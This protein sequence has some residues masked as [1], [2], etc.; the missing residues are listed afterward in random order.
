MDNAVTFC[1][2]RPGPVMHVW[3]DGVE[4]A[5]VPLTAHAALALVADLVK[6]IRPRT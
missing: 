3:R 6:A 4:V 2:I 1:K 5:Q